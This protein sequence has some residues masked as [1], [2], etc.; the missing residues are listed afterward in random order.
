VVERGNHAA[1]PDPDKVGVEEISRKLAGQL[2]TQIVPGQG[3]SMSI[4]KG[5]CA[6][7]LPL[8]TSTKHLKTVY[9]STGPFLKIHYFT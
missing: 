8:Y 3:K 9:T 5:V 6:I 7:L 2:E 4:P 1:T